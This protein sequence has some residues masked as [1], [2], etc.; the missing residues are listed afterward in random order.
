MTTLLQNLLLET[1]P[2]DI[3]PILKSYIHAILPKLEREFSA[4]PAM[5]GD[6]EITYQTLLQAGNKYARENA[7]RYSKWQN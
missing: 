4:A 7:Q 2:A 6:K 5:G 3:D 1:L